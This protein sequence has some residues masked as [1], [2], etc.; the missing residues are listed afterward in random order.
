MW[1]VYKTCEECCYHYSGWANDQ[2][3]SCSS[4]KVIELCSWTIFYLNYF[5]WSKV[6]L[7]FWNLKTWIFQT[8]SNGE[9]L[10]MEVVGPQKFFLRVSREVMKLHSLQFFIWNHIVNEIQ[11]SISHIWNSNFVNDLK[12]KNAQP[13][14]CRSYKVMKLCSWQVFNFNPFSASENRF[15]L[16]VV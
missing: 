16:G 5:C 7:N 13:E 2:N 3:K 6:H 11:I 8:A 14:S 1:E 4:S 15:T 12:W 9:T 10:N